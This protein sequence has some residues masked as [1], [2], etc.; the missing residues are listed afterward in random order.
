MKVTSKEDS[1]YHR[2]R[3]LLVGSELEQIDK[4]RKHF[5]SPEQFT[6]DVSQVLPQAIAKSLQKDLQM[7]E[8]LAPAIGGI[9]DHLINRDI[10]KFAKA[11][12]P[13][14]GPA[15]R[16]SIAESF[17]QMIQTFNKTIEQAF[18]W[19]GIKWRFESLRTGM[20]IAQIAMLN[21]LVYRVEQ[22]FLIHRET[23]LLLQHIHQEDIDFKNA[24][25]ISAM[26]T[27][28]GD[29]VGDSFNQSSNETLD[30]IEIGEL[31]IWV[32]R[33]PEALIAIA[34]RGEAPK[35][36][37][38]KVSSILE[39]IH[40]RFSQELRV[41]DGDTNV[42]ESCQYYLRQ[43][44]DARYK[45]QKKST[46]II[47]LGAWFILIGLLIFWLITSIHSRM[48]RTEYVALLEHEPGYVITKTSWQDGLF[49]IHGLRDPLASSFDHLISQSN[50]DPESVLH[51]FSP[52][53]SLDS[54][55]IVRRIEKITRSPD[56]VMLS[57]NQG[58]LLVSGFATSDWITQFK[59]RM[60]YFTGIDNI[61]T[62]RLKDEIDLSHLE[63]PDTVDFDVDINN[64][65]VKA[66]GYAPKLWIEQSSHKAKTIDG[67]KNY[68]TSTLLVSFDTNQLNP[69]ETVSIDW[70]E[71]QLVIKGEATQDW[72]A[73]LKNVVNDF[74]AITSIDKK[75]LVNSTEL[76]LE[77]Q[78]RLLEKTIILFDSSLSFDLKDESQL[79]QA[80]ILIFEIAKTAKSLS[81]EILITV[82]GYS[83]SVGSFEDN[84]FLSLER[85][86]FVT[87]KIYLSGISPKIISIKG[88]ENPVKKESNLEEQ[89]YN[90]RVEF[91]VTLYNSQLT[92]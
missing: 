87:Q 13:V 29:F 17:R 88:I 49:V 34:I 18:T 38:A 4:L 9:F 84:R 51:Q 83:D 53:Q 90:R 77:T 75:S 79:D 42:F 25:I 60:A 92:Q 40:Q 19:Q 63:A 58:E 73:S 80:V 30:Q 69:P 32:E 41:F 81:R 6:V 14:I 67:I 20:P 89:A 48:Q 16:K 44:I 7:V 37:R 2:L 3:E 45:E 59:Q 82:Q 71:G 22:V 86:D 36:N 10:N 46:S 35:Q 55:L 47:A 76:T 64:G 70:H 72:I 1:D 57:L 85:A 31:S 12:F 78:E 21:G 39:K 28:I 24:D 8:S 62:L 66:S 68:D 54:E 33:G 65:V 61:D 5:D 11:L 23:G 52:Y 26:L 91:K 74:P 50:V 56:N 27:A 15:I 43:C